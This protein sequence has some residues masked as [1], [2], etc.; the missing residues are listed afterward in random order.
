MTLNL[1]KE[2]LMTNKKKW[3]GILVIIL[4]FG[5]TVISC[6]GS[7]RLTEDDL[8]GT[9]I[10]GES[11]DGR[12][13]F[14]STFRQGGTGLWSRSRSEM[15]WKLTRNGSRLEGKYDW[16]YGPETNQ[17]ARDL[18]IKFR[19]ISMSE[20]GRVLTVEDLSMRNFRMM[21]RGHRWVID[22]KR[23]N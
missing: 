3:L 15:S 9:W 10:T 20:D 13:Q 18:P 12:E 17:I 14:R 5:M 2:E 6:G 16:Q 4:I 11:L 8:L 19:F 1:S 22:W 21:I 23:V 7:I